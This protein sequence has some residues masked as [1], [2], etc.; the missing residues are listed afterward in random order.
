MASR[1]DV[2]ELLKNTNF[3]KRTAEEEREQLHTYFVETE[4]WRSVFGGEIDV[5]YGAKGSGKSAIYSLIAQNTDALRERGIIFTEGENPQG[6]T[7]FQI[8]TEDDPVTEFQYNTL[9]KLYFC[10]LAANEMRAHQIENANASRVIDALSDANLLPASFTL[11]RT[12]RYITDFLKTFFPKDIEAGVALDQ[13]TG[14][15][16]GL[17]GK[18]SLREPTAS[19][20]Q[21]GIQSVDTL[22][23]CSNAAFKEAGL[24]LWLLLDRLDVAFSEHKEIENLALRGLFRAYLDMRN[25]R[26]LCPKIFLRSDIW[27]LITETG[28]REA[29]HIEKTITIRWSEE[30][31]LNL[32]IRRALA[33]KTIWEFYDVDPGEILAS[34]DKQEQFFRRIF[35]S[36]VD[37]GINKPTTFNW[38]L[39]RTSDE[40]PWPAPR[41]IIH[42]LNELRDV[43][44]AR[45]ERGE[46]APSEERLFEQIS[47]KEA[48]PA[49]SR[50]KLEQTVYAE[51]PH[52][53]QYIEALRE[54][55]ATQNLKTL[56]QI[57]QLDEN[58]CKRV[59]GELESVGVLKPFGR[60]D[61]K[62]WQ[63]PFLYRPALELV[64]GRE[65]GV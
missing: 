32:I 13:N 56:R 33:N 21:Q 43:Q 27:R 62:E 36:Q 17:S 10:C 6:A 42:F 8:L 18:I 50:A 34:F 25:L 23:E 29:S 9:W 2:L 26:A 5:I 54:R 16:V 53:K 22:L 44:I 59:A 41:E 61:R 19:Q 65:E 64:Q 55:K 46:D 49:V 52:L 1:T 30:D 57:W 20:E 45:Y 3:G 12:I 51:A 63:V 48:L 7:A 31:L 4:Y 24:C 38:L 60:A 58:E 14:L 11:R 35:P 47:F 28:F 40:A 15:P 37:S 39:S